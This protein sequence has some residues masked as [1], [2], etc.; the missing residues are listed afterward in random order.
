VFVATSWSKGCTAIG[1]QRRWHVGAPLWTCKQKSKHCPGPRNSKLCLLLSKRCWHF[2][3]ALMG[4]SSSNIRIVESQSVVYGIVLWLKRSYNTLSAENSEE[5]WQMVLFCVMTNLDL[6]QQQW[7]LERF[8]NWNSIFFPAQHKL[9]SLPI[10]LPY[11]RTDQRCVTWTPVYKLKHIY[12][13]QY[14]LQGSTHILKDAHEF[15]KTEPRRSVYAEIIFQLKRSLT[16]REQHN[17]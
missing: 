17:L 10:W 16:L 7:Q 8:E 11:I 1:C 3:G 4:L 14:F 9:R 5:Y 6:I 13:C 12:I 15:F 2:F